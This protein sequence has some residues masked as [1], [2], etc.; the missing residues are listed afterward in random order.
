MKV[1]AFLAASVVLFSA[2]LP[3]WFAAGIA[4]AART[5]GLEPSARFSVELQPN[6]P[7]SDF[8]TYPGPGTLIDG[9]WVTVN[10]ELR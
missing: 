5:D 9:T 8:F 2:S 3:S 10:T 6:N 7:N 4:R 1:R